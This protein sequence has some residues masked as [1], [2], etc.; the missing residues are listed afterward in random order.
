MTATIL[1]GDFVNIPSIMVM[2]FSV[3]ITKWFV[4]PDILS[5]MLMFSGEESVEIA[6][7]FSF[8]FNVT[9]LVFEVSVELEFLP[10]IKS[11]LLGLFPVI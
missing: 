6:V 2:F 10:P 1:F 3:L 11:H 5:T 4:F 7:V 9:L 8:S